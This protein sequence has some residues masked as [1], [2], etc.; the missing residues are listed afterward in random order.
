M[1][2][3]NALAHQPLFTLFI[4]PILRGTLPVWE[5]SFYLPQEPRKKIWKLQRMDGQLLKHFESQWTLGLNYTLK[6]NP[7]IHP[8]C[9]QLGL[10]RNKWTLPFTKYKLCFSRWERKLQRQGRQCEEPA[11]DWLRVTKVLPHKAFFCL[12]PK[13][14]SPFAG[15]LLIPCRA[16]CVPLSLGYEPSQGSIFR[17]PL[18]LQVMKTCSP[19]LWISSPTKPDFIPPKSLEVWGMREE[20]G[21]DMEWGAPAFCLC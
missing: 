10:K 13:M 7:E 15:W 16:I 19:F 17:C 4:F 18:E 5:T 12:S 3:R 1:F 2:N 20:G 21:G 8:A 14:T 6:G 11:T 9:P